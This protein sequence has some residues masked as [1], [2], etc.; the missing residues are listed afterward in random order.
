MD[1]ATETCLAFNFTG[2]GANWNNFP[3]SHACYEECLP[4]K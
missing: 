4:C 2:C 3:N 1:I